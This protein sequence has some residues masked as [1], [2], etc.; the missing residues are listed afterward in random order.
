MNE[1]KEDMP[2]EPTPPFRV[3]LVDQFEGHCEDGF[4]AVGYFDRLDDAIAKAREITAK[5][6]RESGSFHNWDGMTAT[7]CATEHR[8]GR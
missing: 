3:D 1:M 4:S 6:I 2:H 8:P 7:V 5:A